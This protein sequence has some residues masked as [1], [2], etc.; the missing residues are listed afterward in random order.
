LQRR[1]DA[2]TLVESY[3]T[4]DA[5]LTPRSGHQPALDT[6]PPDSLLEAEELD[7]LAAL[8]A[9]TDHLLAE[10][11][12]EHADVMEVDLPESLSATSLMRLYADPGGLARS[13]ARP[14]PIPYRPVGDTLPCLAGE[15]HRPAVIARA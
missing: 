1:R 5:E 2:A 15:P 13:L 14:T 11:Q 8:D 7:R 3:R 4:A 12:R 10:A 9:D 6:R